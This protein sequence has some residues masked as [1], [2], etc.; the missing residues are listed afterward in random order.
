M[1]VIF[2]PTAP[3]TYAL[4]D[5]ASPALRE[6]LRAAQLLCNRVTAESAAETNN[7][8]RKLCL[9]I[10]ASDSSAV[11]H[12]DS[13]PAQRWLIWHRLARLLFL[14]CAYQPELSRIYVRMVRALDHVLPERSPSGPVDVQPEV[15]AALHDILTPL[16]PSDA[17]EG[18]PPAKPE[19]VTA[20]H[21]ARSALLA[22]M[23]SLAEQVYLGIGLDATTDFGAT[24]AAIPAAIRDD[25]EADDAERAHRR[26]MRSLI[27]RGSARLIGELIHAEISA[28]E[29]LDRTVDLANRLLSEE[30][31]DAAFCAEQ[32]LGHLADAIITMLAVAGK[33]LASKDPEPVQRTLKA[34]FSL[35]ER[36]KEDHTVIPGKVRFAARDLCESALRGTW[37]VTSFG[38][39]GVGVAKAATA[40]KTRAEVALE[41]AAPG[42]GV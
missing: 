9:T 4:T 15:T 39:S 31:V 27:L 26:Q 19:A 12:T 42:T 41:P 20:L 7:D 5:T 35:L 40:N 25:P 30:I 36:A 21:A 22:E 28:R 10:A 33:D 3:L 8:F 6:F 2:E 1:D 37:G 38:P 11:E 14:Q 18:R 24:S 32:P 23:E 17:G 29:P 16:G 13:E 34:M